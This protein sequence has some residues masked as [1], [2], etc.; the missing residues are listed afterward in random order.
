MGL[1]NG[2]LSALFP[3]APEPLA[4]VRAGRTTLV[5][6]KVVPRDLIVSPLT[7][8][9]CV[10]YQYT[11]EEWRQSRVNGV[12]GDGFWQLVDRDEAIAEFYLQDGNARAI[13]APHGARV[14]RA[15]GVSVTSVELGAL[16]RRAQQLLIM[17]NDEV[18]VLAQVG[19]ADDMFDDARAYR[20]SPTRM[21]LHAPESGEILIR[22]VR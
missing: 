18:E 20:A 9:R 11:I 22:L 6:G 17:P 8:D 5:R 21:I 2:V 12:A 16:G 7:G 10:Y 13:V 15:R 19:H 1:I 3:P 4:E 14:E